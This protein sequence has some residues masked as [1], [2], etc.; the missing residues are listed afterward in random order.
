MTILN[1]LVKN[2]NYQSRAD[3]SRP[4]DLIQEKMDVVRPEPD[5]LSHHKYVPE[6]DYDYYYAQN[7]VAQGSEWHE[8]TFNT[9]QQIDRLGIDYDYDDYETVA[10]DNETDYDYESDDTDKDKDY[11]LYYYYY[12]DYVDPEDLESSQVLERLPQPSYRLA[13]NETK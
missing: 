11:E 6:E 8:S 1:L 10:N 13:S 3:I 12:Y 4:P 2:K 9:D 7:E 5:K